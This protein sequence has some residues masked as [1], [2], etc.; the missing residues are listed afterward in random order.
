MK[1]KEKETETKGET[2]MAINECDL[3][4]R[5]VLFGLY[6]SLAAVDG[7]VHE[8]EKNYLNQIAKRL[9]VNP[10][11]VGDLKEEDKWEINDIDDC[12]EVLL[13]VVGLTMIDGVMEISEMIMSGKIHHLFG[14]PAALQNITYMTIID[15]A[16]IGNE[17]P[18]PSHPK[19][20][21]VLNCPED[22]KRIIGKVK[23]AMSEGD[24]ASLVNTFRAAKQRGII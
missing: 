8:S 19:L 21:S 23:Q 24:M 18:R 4:T 13:D 7:E 20:V 2:D 12:L 22:R 1:L 6:S 5:E 15:E 16:D 9:D 11:C 14:V 3:K 10:D 17:T